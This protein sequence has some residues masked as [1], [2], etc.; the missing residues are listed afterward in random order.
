[1]TNLCSING[2]IQ[3]ADE[4]VV[5]ISDLALQRGY[6]VFDFG[7]TYRGKLFHFN[8]NIR[9][10]RKSAKELGLEISSTDE[11]ITN[12]AIELIEKSELA[13]PSVRLL[14]TGGY[15]ASLGQ[16]NFIMIAE[17]LPTYPEDSYTKGIRLITERYQRELPQV[18]SINYLNSI[19]LD[20]KKRESGAM[21]LLYYNEKSITESP[22]SNFF[23]F[24]ENTL[25]TPKDNILLGITRKVILSLAADYFNI[26][27][28]DIPIDELG[29]L[30]EVFLTS[31]SKRV[32]PVTDIDGKAVGEGCVGRRTIKLMDLFDQ[33]TES[34]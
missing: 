6:G 20:Q 13:I 11:E 16:P 19:R 22:K 8:E 28:R 25:I 15:S 12:T 2:L 29:S 17:E 9:R 3:P 7:R 5:G 24:K 31:T 26:E 30:D 27:I 18:K 21:D 32:M 23:A 33:Y 10:L 34:Y 4:G 14:L 1:M